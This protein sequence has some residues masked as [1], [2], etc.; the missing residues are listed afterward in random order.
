MKKLLVSV[1]L[2]ISIATSVQAI[3]SDIKNITDFTATG[4]GVAVGEIGSGIYH[5][6]LSWHPTGTVSTCS[7]K[8]QQS[9]NGTSWSD[10]IAGE[11]C[12]SSGASAI[13]TGV[14]NYVRITLVTFSGSG[15]LRARYDGWVDRS[16]GG[17]GGGAPTGPAG[18]GLSGTYPNP[19]IV[20][21]G[22]V[23]AIQFD[24]AGTLGGDANLT[25]VPA[26]GLKNL[27]HAA[28]GNTSLVDHF[29]AT[30][31]DIE[32]TYTGALPDQFTGIYSNFTLN[33]ASVA[34]GLI[35]AG[36]LVRMRI[37]PADVHDYL[38]LEG[39]DFY[40][41]HTGS[42]HLDY[43][44]AMFMQGYNEGSGVIDIGTGL[45]VFLANYGSGSMTT[46]ISIHIDSE[47]GAGY[48]T[49]YGLK[50]DDQ[51]AGV[52][53]YAIYTGSGLVR[54][55]SL[56]ASLPVFTDGSKNLVSLTTNAALNALLPSQG[57]NS[58]K[59][60][61]TNGTDSSWATIAFSAITAGTNT[62]AL[63]VGT[64]GSLTISGSGTINA[65]SLGGAVA[66]SYALLNSPAFITPAL[67]TPSSGTLTNVTGL[68]I[69]SGVS[70]L[71]SGVATFLGT[72]SSANL[73][74]ALTTKTG[75][76][77][78][79]F[80]TSPS[81]TTGL[82]SPVVTITQGT[83]AADALQI[84]GTVTWNNSG[85]VGPA[86]KLNATDTSSNAAALLV[87]LGVG[88][89]S[90]VSKW[91]VDKTGKV[92]QTGIILGPSGSNSAPTYSFASRTGTGLYNR[93]EAASLNSDGVA[94]LEVANPAS[95]RINTTATWGSSTT[96]NLDAPITRDAAGT[97]AFRD[98]TNA[99][100]TRVYRTFTNA[101]NYERLA[102][103]T[104]S[105][106]VELAAETAGTGTDDIDV[107]LTPSGV[108]RVNFPGGT[109]LKT[110]AALTDGAGAS[111]G[112]LTNAPAVG[113]PTKWIPIND[114]GTTRYIPAW[115]VAFLGFRP[116]H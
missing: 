69:S 112:T 114:N 80:D 101:S 92:T 110:R 12:T 60:L 55:G 106:Y 39:A 107:R 10:L 56:T 84:N 22:P 65:T 9:M 67:G 43:A 47:N 95:V 59:F 42:G 85:I 13:G 40:F 28:L 100:T 81:F 103:Q 20:A 36:N 82:T 86:W 26:S 8:V 44:T 113:N 35:A 27:K 38:G 7:V 62:A 93:S 68:P 70:G 61:T 31:L 30:I 37:D 5:H 17:G 89:G 90:F 18:G 74:A 23:N 16:A 75:T 66:A 77:L 104:G 53:N 48:T 72:P 29:G 41:D 109:L 78:A 50:I 97:L 6:R 1:L 108:G 21:A 52:T 73:L 76:G 79:V 98:G 96:A 2:L 4:S 102:L 57:S 45:E 94:Y 11:T 49:L 34:P 63:V 88:G 54:L 32:E 15:S 71:G 51:T 64:G 33:P 14:A 115:V 87:D 83:I 116:A 24:S 111:A 19:N 3:Q 25:W 91:K 58:G 105:D 99:Q 46:G